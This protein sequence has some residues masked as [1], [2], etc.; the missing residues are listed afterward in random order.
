MFKNLFLHLSVCLCVVAWSV[1]NIQ[2]STIC[3]VVFWYGH[4]LQ[5]V[6]KSSGVHFQ[7]L[8]STIF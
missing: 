3:L 8:F 1:V 2:H 5:K 4:H 6:N 7:M